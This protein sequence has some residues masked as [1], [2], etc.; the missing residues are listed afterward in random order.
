MR[1]AASPLYGLALLFSFAHAS[2]LAADGTKLEKPVRISTIKI[3][4]TRVIGRVAA[5]DDAGFD[6]LDDKNVSQRVQW[7]QLPPK[8][9]M[10]VHA[11][12]LAKGTAKDW[13]TAGRVMYHLEG[14]KEW[15]DRAF[16]RALRMDP[17][18]KD[19]IEQA[20]KPP[21]PPPAAVAGSATKPAG[22]ELLG[23]AG[24]TGSQADV[25]K[26]L[27]GPQ[28]DAEQAESVKA[29]RRFA[30]STRKGKDGSLRP[31]ETRYFLVYSDLRPDETQKWAGLLDKMY[32]RL[33]EL[34]GVAPGT[35]LFRGKA[36][37]FAFANA[38]DFHAHEMDNY[39]VD[40][41]G[42]AGYCH[43]QFDGMV[44]ISFYRLPDD[45]AFAHVLVH[46]SV[47]GFLHRYRSHVYVPVWAN[48]GLA[49]VIA[50]ELVPNKAAHANRRQQAIDALNQHGGPGDDFFA[51]KRFAVWQY[52]VAENLMAYM[53]AANRKGYVAFI[54]GI[55][56][57]LPAEESLTKHYGA[58]KDRIV[59]AFMD[60]MG[61]RKKGK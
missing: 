43:S 29:L 50:A 40:T 16:A 51:T 1:T 6:L 32:G 28:T 14:G 10:E 24:K 57:G 26:K 49:D 52:P 11:V 55:K 33:L 36:L 54:N 20:K 30:E 47:H 45:L 59:A 48:E 2:V 13:V 60:S 39:K 46:E 18:V 41:Q 37:V 12:L 53:I 4:N 8:S 3:D 31:V 25:L 21:L 42:L 23:E 27:W 19:A 15:G 7:S 34:F 5:F 56:D 38:A 44:H 58:D 61:V 17:K 22:G 9:V 35:N